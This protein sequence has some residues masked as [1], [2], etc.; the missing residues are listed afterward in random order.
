LI[1]VYTRLLGKDGEEKVVAVVEEGRRR[2]A[3]KKSKNAEEG[4]LMSSSHGLVTG[5]TWR[6]RTDDGSNFLPP[7]RFYIILSYL[8]FLS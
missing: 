4:L 3:A 7:I 1:V 8:I 2:N 6:C 5:D